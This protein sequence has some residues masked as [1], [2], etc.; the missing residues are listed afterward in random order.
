[1]VLRRPPH[2]PLLGAAAWG[3]ERALVPGVWQRGAGL[4]GVRSCQGP[5]RATRQPAASMATAQFAPMG[6]S[7]CPGNVAAI[8]VQIQG[9]LPCCNSLCLEKQCQR[10]R[11]PTEAVAG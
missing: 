11:G 9:P 7:N 8:L 3:R 6:W 5:K 2:S 4:L 1:M 10:N